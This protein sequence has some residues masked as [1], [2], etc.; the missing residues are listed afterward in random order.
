MCVCTKISLYCFVARIVGSFYCRCLSTHINSETSSKCKH[1]NTV[2]TNIYTNIYISI[3]I[4]IYTY[5]LQ[6]SS[7]DYLSV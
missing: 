2:H 1:S 3:Y 4:E 7:M 6:A 5:A